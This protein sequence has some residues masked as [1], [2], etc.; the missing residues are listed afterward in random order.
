MKKFKFLDRPHAVT[1]CFSGLLLQIFCI[2]RKYNGRGGSSVMLCLFSRRGWG[3][4]FVLF[5]HWQKI[6][7]VILIGT[8]NFIV[9]FCF[10]FFQ[11]RLCFKAWNLTVVELTLFPWSFYD[12]L[13]SSIFTFDVTLLFKK[14]ISREDSWGS[15]SRILPF[16]NPLHIFPYRFLFFTLLIFGNP[17]WD[18]FGGTETPSVLEDLSIGWEGFKFVKF[19]IDLSEAAVPGRKCG[20]WGFPFAVLIE[21][22]F[23]REV[24][25]LKKEF[26]FWFVLRKQFLYLTG[27]VLFEKWFLGIVLPFIVKAHKVFKHIV[28][29]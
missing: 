17:F 7:E 3:G 6:F 10:H 24:R 28:G 8:S 20:K 12:V 18:S 22:I 26:F 5:Q 4:V 27:V 19:F 15:I 13:S 21:I 25:F 2:A 11:S 14:P 29:I 23:L 16:F 1:D 9:L